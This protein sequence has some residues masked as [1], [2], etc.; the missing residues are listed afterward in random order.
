MP[1]HLTTSQTFEAASNEVHQSEHLTADQP[2]TFVEVAFYLHSNHFAA[3]A[4]SFPR[5][6]KVILRMPLLL[7]MISNYKPVVVVVV[8]DILLLP[9]LPLLY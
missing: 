5:K 7:A 4:E 1:E 9:L 2:V 6:Y 3:L 8:V